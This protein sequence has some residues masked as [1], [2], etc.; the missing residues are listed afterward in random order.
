MSLHHYNPLATTVAYVAVLFRIAIATLMMTFYMVPLPGLPFN[1][2]Q[3]VSVPGTGSGE[4]R[5]DGSA[6]AGTYPISIT[7]FTICRR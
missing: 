6:E 7:P 1:F 2:H 5:H 3:D 4:R